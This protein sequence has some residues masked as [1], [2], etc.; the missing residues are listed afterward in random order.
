MIMIDSI[1]IRD[2]A[3]IFA[4]SC[5]RC[6]AQLLAEFVKVLLDLMT[7]TLHGEIQLIQ[8]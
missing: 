2:Q 4:N 8:D 5:A 3:R 7:W 6:K 1:F